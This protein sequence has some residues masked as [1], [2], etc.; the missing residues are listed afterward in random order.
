M[1]FNGSEGA[2]IDS[3]TAA[4]WTKTYRD[5]NPA[6][7]QSRFFGKE[8][9]QAILNQPGCVG[10]RFYYGNDGTVPQLL[11]VGANSAENDQLGESF[12]VADESV[13]GPPCSGQANM[14]NS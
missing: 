13:K 3:A 6:A 9:L 11:A 2:A 8:I 10:I 1:A 4:K 7:I 12:V 5:A 14:L